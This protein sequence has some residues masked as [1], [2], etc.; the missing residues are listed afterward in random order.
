ML[1]GS[2]TLASKFFS[3]KCM[4][5]LF[6]MIKYQGGNVSLAL[7]LQTAVPKVKSFEAIIATQRVPSFAVH[8]I[9]SFFCFTMASLDFKTSCEAKGLKKRNDRHLDSTGARQQGGPSLV[10][11]SDVDKLDMTLGKRRLL[12]KGI[13]GLRQDSGTGLGVD[14]I[15]H[16][17]SNDSKIPSEDDF[18]TNPPYFQ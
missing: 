13:T 2:T 10:S 3:L 8:V 11:E 9:F 5:D 14:A 12:C 1:C 7:P 6:I 4:I 16:R 17:P 15:S 18:A